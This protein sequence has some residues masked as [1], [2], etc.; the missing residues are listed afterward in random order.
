M[1][2]IKGHLLGII[3]TIAIFGVVLTAMTAAFTSVSETIGQRAT[4]AANIAQVS[5]D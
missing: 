4:D 2:E 3:L 1:S 5:G